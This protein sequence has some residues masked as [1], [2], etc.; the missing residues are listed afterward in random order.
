LPG[1]AQLD[2]GT[3][4]WFCVL[5]L[6]QRPLWAVRWRATRDL[7]VMRLD[8]RLTRPEFDAAL[9]KGCHDNRV[10]QTGLASASTRACGLLA[11]LSSLDSRQLDAGL[12]TQVGCR[13]VDGHSVRRGP[14]LDLLSDTAALEVATHVPRRMHRKRPAPSDC[15]LWKR[16][17]GDSSGDDC[18]NL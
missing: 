3:L 1:A 18:P 6:G 17:A 2:P 7:A 14:R 15:E 10:L 5:A 9:M 11:R 4:V 12:P 8:L 16:R 13:F